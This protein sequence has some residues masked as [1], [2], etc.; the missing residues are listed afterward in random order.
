MKILIV[1]DEP[2]ILEILQ[3]MY[4]ESFADVTVTKAVDGA[5]AL[6]LCWQH[7]FD[8]ICT[9]YHMPALDGLELTQ[10]I[11]TKIGP[12]QNTGIVFLSGFIPEFKFKV[13]T[14]ANVFL[15]DKPVE[16]D[17]LMR[18]SSLASRTP[19]RSMLV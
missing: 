16:M 17:R 12:N 6:H 4:E 19:L 5:Q 14:I 1:D 11:R 13:E 7:T 9:D 15:L 2:L 10:M 18:I 3:E 8:L